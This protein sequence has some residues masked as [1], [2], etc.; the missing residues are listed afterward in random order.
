MQEK[1]KSESV[2]YLNAMTEKFN[3]CANKSVPRSWD[4]IDNQMK[5][6]ESEI[7]E[8]RDA[9]TARDA[10]ELLDGY[11]DGMVTLLGMRDMLANLGFDV[12]GAESTIADNNDTKFVEHDSDGFWDLLNATKYHYGS[13]G[14][15][16]TTVFNR[17]YNCYTFVDKN[18][19]V[20]KPYN[21]KSVNLKSFIP[22]TL[23]GVQTNATT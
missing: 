7:Q 8:M 6:I 2:S 17:Y 5:I 4:D 11:V 12:Q 10:T 14:I 18:G 21:Y 3:A 15:E 9:I 20:R 16:V 13:Q 19:K 1:T 23:F 22:A